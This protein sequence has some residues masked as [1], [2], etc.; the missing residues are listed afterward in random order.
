MLKKKRMK[1]NNKAFSLVELIVA[2]AVGSIVMLIIFAFIAS[3]TNFFKRQM[4]TV[5]LQNELQETSNKIT[6]AIMEASDIKCE[7]VGDMVY[8]ETGI[9]KLKSDKESTS[10]ETSPEENSK[11]KSKLIVWTG[12]KDTTVYVIDFDVL[13]SIRPTKDELS[14]KYQGY[15]C[16]SHVVKF[17]FEFNSDFYNDPY[18]VWEESRGATKV[19]CCLRKPIFH[20]DLRLESEQESV[21]KDTKLTKVR[22]DL[23]GLSYYGTSYELMRNRKDTVVETTTA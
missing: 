13:S 15:L 12:E 5:N 6:D 1:N 18:S 21:Q 8:I 17:N 11:T 19:K 20:V 4:D 10:E 14:K 3:G 22:N 23:S 2:V 7:K 9:F 16:S